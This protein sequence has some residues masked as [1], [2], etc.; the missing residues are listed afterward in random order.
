[1]LIEKALRLEQSSHAVHVQ[2][3]CCSFVYVCDCYVYVT[4]RISFR[5]QMSWR[6]VP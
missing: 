6:P 4:C 5:L 3:L 1:M 2:S